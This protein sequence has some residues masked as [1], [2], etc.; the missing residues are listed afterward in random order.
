MPARTK[1]GGTLAGSGATVAGA[2]ATLPAG[3]DLA[4]LQPRDSHLFLAAD[5][6]R[7]TRLYRI[8]DVNPAARQVTLDAAPTVAG[9][10]DWEAG[11]RV[12]RYE[13]FLPAPGDGTRTGVDLPTSRA[14]PVTYAQGGVTA[15]DDK[16]HTADDPDGG[17]PLGR[18]AG[19]RGP[20]RRARDDLPGPP[21]AAA[22]AARPAGFRSASSPARPTTT[23]S[24]TTR[25]AGCPRRTS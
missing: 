3:T 10:S 16:A 22:R 13:L 18:P 25:C 7:P 17:H 5:T 1:A 9:A 6:A 15:V 14:E 19:E 2:V 20:D 23:G 24:P 21:G 12:R 11:T 8:M 4:G